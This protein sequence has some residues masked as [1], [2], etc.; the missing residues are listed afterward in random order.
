LK[1]CHFQLRIIKD[2]KFINGSKFRQEKNLFLEIP[3]DCGVGSKIFSG[4]IKNFNEKPVM[5][6]VYKNG[7]EF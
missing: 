1:D 6:E 7:F 3:T 5:G 2:S 4:G